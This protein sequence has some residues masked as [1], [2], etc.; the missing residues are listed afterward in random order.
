VPGTPPDACTA[1]WKDN[2]S[3]A[4]NSDG[5][6]V[7]DPLVD[8]ALR[9]FSFLGQAQQLKSPSVSDL[10]SYRRDGAVHWL[11]DIPVHPAVQLAAGR[12]TPEPS[13]PV[14][15]VDRV[16]RL[17]PPAPEDELSAWL[18]GPLD[19]PRREPAL[20]EERY[21]PEPPSG[22]ADHG[23]EPPSRRVASSDLPA[24]GEAVR[25]F[26]REWRAWAEQDLRDESLRTFYG[27]F[28]ST[29][30]SANGHPRSSSSFSAAGCSPGG[31]TRIPRY[32]VTCSSRPSRSFSTTPPVG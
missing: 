23:G 29:Y 18:E 31:P 25:R 12:S 11:D 19:D 2:V 26:Q 9:L 16:R 27:G 8:R 5:T 14:L 28:F 21:L 13:D 32:G 17:D 4:V 7:P 30:V 22:D 20:R 15:A 24:V 1:P 6:N 3:A 10:D